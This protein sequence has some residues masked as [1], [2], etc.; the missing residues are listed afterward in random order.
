MQGVYFGGAPGFA[1]E[2]AVNGR[3]ISSFDYVAGR[4]SIWTY[5]T[6]PWFEGLDFPRSYVK[7]VWEHDEIPFIRF[8]PVSKLDYSMFEETHFSLQHILD[9]QFDAQLRRWADAARDTNIPILLEF[10]TEVNNPFPWNGFYSGAGRTDGYGDPTYPDGPERFR[11][12]YRHIVTLFRAEGATNVTW[13]FHADTPWSDE[14]WWTTYLPGEPR[15]N[16]PAYYYPG[17][18]YVDWLGLSDY[19]MPAWQDGHILSLEEKLTTL[20]SRPLALLEIGV[21]EHG[22]GVKPQW[23][24]DAFAFIRSGALPRIRAA[25][26]WMAEDPPFDTDPRTSPEALHAFRDAVSNPAFGAQPQFSGDCRPSTPVGVKATS[27]LRGRIL[28]QWHAVPN[29]AHYQVR[30]AG[31]LVVTTDDPKF[32]D[33]SAAPKRRYAYVVRAVNPFGVSA[34]SQPVSGERR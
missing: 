15:W 17:D 6:Q 30:R 19:G 18:D 4:H 5:F 3:A 29:A 23:I 28:V 13:F 10:G 21:G 24:R 27:A 34:F 22:P 11:D 33:S 16:R 7:I 31:R 26:W 25:S 32:I 12:A 14:P 9:G 2:S 8:W 20:S 1:G